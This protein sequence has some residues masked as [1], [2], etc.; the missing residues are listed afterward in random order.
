[1]NNRPTLRS[2]LLPVVLTGL[3]CFWPAAAKAQSPATDPGERFA[4]ELFELPG[5]SLG[6]NIQDI[7]Q[8]SVGFM[9]FA[10]QSGLHRYDGSRIETFQHDRK[11]S[12]TISSDYVE[13]LLIDRQGRLWAGTYGD[14]L[15]L[16]DHNTE[17]FTRYLK[18]ENGASGLTDNNVMAL[19]EDREGYIWVGIGDGLHRYDPV[20]DRWK[21]FRH[22]P[23]NPRSLSHNQ[24]YELYVDAS[25]VLWVGAGF[26]WR[27]FKEEDGGLNRYHPSTENFTVYRK[28]P[29]KEYTLTDNKVRAIFEDS[30]GTF[31]V[32]AYGDGLHT[33]DRQ[34]GQF[35]HYPSD[36]EHP[37]QLSRPFIID[38]DNPGGVS[39]IAEDRDQGLW[40]GAWY[41]GLNYYDLKTQKLHRFDNQTDGEYFFRLGRLVN[42]SDN[43]IGTFLWCFFQSQDGTIW[44]SG[45]NG[46]SGQMLLRVTEVEKRFTDVKIE[47]DFERSVKRVFS[48]EEDPE[49]NLWV[50]TEYGGV[51]KRD[52]NTG[53][54]EQFLIHQSSPTYRGINSA[55][56]VKADRRGNIWIGSFGPGGGLTRLQSSSGAM[57]HYRPDSEDPY[58][59]RGGQ[60]VDMLYD[61]SDRLWI[62]TLEG[63]LHL[64]D[65]PN[66][67]FYTEP[68]AASALPATDVWDLFESSNGDIWAVAPHESRKDQLML[69]RFRD[70]WEAFPINLPKSK[71][72]WF[73]GIQEDQKGNFWLSIPAGFIY[74][75]P[76]TGEHEVMPFDLVNEGVMGFTLDEDDN[77]WLVNYDGVAIINPEEK[78]ESQVI[79]YSSRQNLQYAPQSIYR[80]RRGKMLVG[81][82]DGFFELD[83]EALLSDLSHPAPEILLSRF[84]ILNETILP[85]GSSPLSQPIWETGSITLSHW[86][87]IFSFDY[88]MLD[89]SAPDANQLEYKLENYDADWR[90]AEDKRARYIKVPPG[91]YTFRVRGK[92]KRGSWS[93]AE[94]T[95]QLYVRL[96]WWRRWWAYLLFVATAS[97]AAFS[98]YRFQFTRQL[99][100]AENRRLR[101]LDQ[102]K[103]RLYTNITHEFRTPLTII[104]GMTEQIRSAPGEWMQDGLDMIQRNSRQLLNLVN[105]L[106][107]LRRLESG[108]LPV[109][110]R[111]G[112]VV[113]FLR[114]ILESF[115]SYAES[116][117]VQVHFLTRSP[118]LVMD[119]DPEKLLRIVSNLLSNAIK[120]TPAGGHVYL[121]IEGVSASSLQKP[122]GSGEYLRLEVRDTGVGISPEKLPQ[123][124]DRFYQ[125]DDTDTRRVGGTGVGLALC[126]E[127]VKILQG[128][129]TVESKVGKGAV[130]NLLLPIT[131]QAPLHG[132]TDP[133]EIARETK[134]VAMPDRIIP[135]PDAQSRVGAGQP[136]LA[137]LVDDHPDVLK[138]LESCLAG[139]YRLEMADNGRSGIE[140]AVETVPDIIIS[141]VMMPEIDG[142]D[143][144]QTLKSDPRTSHIP[145]IL[146]TAKADVESRIEG[147]EHG[148]DAYLSK[149]F[150]QQE[151][152]VRIR[153]LLEIRDK[154]RRHYLS[155]AGLVQPATAEEPEQAWSPP[156]DA[157]V[158]RVRD[159]VFAHLDDYEFSVQLLCR[160]I[161]LSH[162]QLH[163]K[164]TALT[165]LSANRFIRAIRLKQAKELLRDER[166]SITAVAF[167]TGFSDPDYFGRV[168]RKAYGLTPSEYRSRE[169]SSQSP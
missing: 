164:L 40:I 140:R 72:F 54:W 90:K 23:N 41:G 55:L 89:F 75:Y 115:H 107:D 19:A 9:W 31:W 78:R 81:R 63:G 74:F 45:G 100:L 27:D 104:S 141:D 103:T 135:K 145:V 30:Q 10:S 66:D 36:R 70:R 156:E 118:E 117:E 15:N 1:M 24:V 82:N 44:I 56:V 165:G 124:F 142:L 49:G 96:P 92:N 130:F 91:E 20:R 53:D 71:L 160:E 159:I 97:L 35:T 32:G 62:A 162:S 119:Y 166:L 114:Y 13:Y 26:P 108:S 58:S 8:D 116:R 129:I 64:Y 146:L 94:K 67:R 84:E 154:L 80:D 60:V 29:G 51:L 169:V 57:T 93:P 88:S 122:G 46:H 111:Q 34:T 87:N 3:A 73:S 153:K 109:R 12:T 79:Q 132:I 127:L 4:F 136:P 144:C 121:S 168:F 25:G 134:A 22:D 83:R 21:V 150:N 98:I 113:A 151:L 37:E 120:F 105:Q 148:A 85:S 110:L 50:G 128:E 158:Q 95:V 86:Q 65:Y 112:D 102:V 149:P 39:F 147:L 42:D 11:D 48:F 101:E 143:L 76:E 138:Y 69:Y 14:G 17:T 52:H 123:I 7:T 106:L 161:G 126:R 2:I 59:L 125:A 167:D 68:D 139:H 133:E 137:L 28:E 16:F 33:F 131:R 155:S 61:R 163:R 5:G 99:Q 77:I 6:N 157:F 38:P 152:L 47:G 43:P 18:S